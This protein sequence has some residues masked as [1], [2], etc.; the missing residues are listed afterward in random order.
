MLQADTRALEQ[1][2]NQ[3]ILNIRNLELG[4]YTNFYITIG[5][6]S[7]LIGGF[8]YNSMTQ[9]TFN[10]YIFG[11]PFSD[12]PNQ[13][14]TEDAGHGGY[15]PL[16]T[17]P[18]VILRWVQIF[19]AGFYICSATCLASS[20]YCILITLM[21]QV[22]GSGLA[23]LGPIGSMTRATRGLKKEMVTTFRVYNVM[24][25]SF[26]LGSFFSFWLVMD[27][28]AAV[29][30]S[31][32]S[33]VIYTISF[34]DFLRIYKNFEY[35]MTTPEVELDAF[36][37]DHDP[38]DDEFNSDIEM[39]KKR[40]QSILGSIKN[41]LNGLFQSDEFFKSNNY[42]ESEQEQNL[43][44]YIKMLDGFDEAFNNEEINTITNQKVTDEIIDQCNNYLKEMEVIEET[45]EN[46]STIEKIEKLKKDLSLKMA[47]KKHFDRYGLLRKELRSVEKHQ[48]VSDTI[49][50]KVQKTV[51]LQKKIKDYSQAVY[52]G[53]WKS[54]EAPSLLTYNQDDGDG[55]KLFHNDIKDKIVKH[56]SPSAVPIQLK[57]FELK[58]QPAIERLQK[59]QRIED[60]EGRYYFDIR[61]LSSEEQR[62]YGQE[63]SVQTLAVQDEQY[64]LR[65]HLPSSAT[66]HDLVRWEKKI[67]QHCFAVDDGVKKVK[68]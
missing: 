51:I 2:V 28:V 45:N 1:N 6:Q 17:N 34:Y 44:L 16:S 19:Q 53:L 46:K 26:G 4:Y 61:E 21:M 8:A 7:A 43:I 58:L 37:E 9:V 23:L 14:Y 63:S 56:R 32:V 33:L 15:K 12:D 64:F 47:L 20:I 36:E 54:S 39:R 38:D 3:N 30:S 67:A 60:Q 13:Q 62:S 31:F 27:I 24:L 48:V 65:F 10:N 57:K 59:I 29:I 55:E 22:F 52:V 66:E 5:T 18:F 42:S 35:D 68:C 49:D 50:L 11:N 25:V 40:Q 41:A